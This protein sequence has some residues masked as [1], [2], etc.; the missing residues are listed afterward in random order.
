MDSYTEEHE[1]INLK[2]LDHLILDCVN[3]HNE[4][5]STRIGLL[6]DMIEDGIATA[7]EAL[8][9]CIK[10]IK[11]ISDLGMLAVIMK[12]G[13]NRNLYVNVKGMGPAHILIY[14]FS[15]LPYD[16]FIRFY[17]LML[18][19]GSSSLSPCYLPKEEKEAKEEKEK[20]EKNDYK[21]HNDRH[22]HFNDNHSKTNIVLESVKE[23]IISKSRTKIELFDTASQVY[24][25]IKSDKCSNS[26]KYLYSVYLNDESIIEWTPEVLTLMLNSR[27][28]NWNNVKINI[29]SETS[30]KE[31]YDMKSKFLKVAVNA[32]FLELATSML[33]LGYRPNYIDFTFWI[34]H[35][36]H[37]VEYVKVESLIKEIEI[38]FLELV[39]RGYKLDLYCVDEIGYVNPEFR[40]KIIE[41]YE[42]PLWQK[43][44]SYTDDLY[45]PDEIKDVIVYLEVDIEASKSSICSNI[46]KIT[47]ADLDSL[48][49]ANRKRNSHLISSKLN[50]LTD[51]INSDPKHNSNGRCDNLNDFNDNPLDYPD[52]LLMYYRD[53]DN[54]TYCFISKDFANLVH[55]GINPSTKK[56]LPTEFVERLK[57]Q[58]KLLNYFGIPLSDPKTVDRLIHDIRKD[59]TLSNKE[60]NSILTKIKDILESR[61]ID[62][63]AMMNSIPI[64]SYITKFNKIG[65]DIQKILLIPESEFDKTI[66]T[67]KSEFSTKMIQIIICYCLYQKLKEDITLVNQ[68]F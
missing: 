36:K 2:N 32:T 38:I 56:R 66:E 8:A 57:S 60:T 13:A 65:I 67:M 46:E 22:V 16:I 61:G 53:T 30:Q 52:R 35:Y 1:H 12:N 37:L 40:V 59:D 5:K 68:F 45:I 44:C 20:K 27:N 42:K 31:L 24:S 29:D 19:F 6:E 15:Q 48:K 47:M 4:T 49:S 3:T 43:V 9:I 54:K 34:A 51:F 55:S 11:N 7:D 39:K 64:K 50:M 10:E 62:E 23:W 17:N 25:Y 26:D 58:I 33:N 14:G 18:L 21:S 41:E 28:S 63:D